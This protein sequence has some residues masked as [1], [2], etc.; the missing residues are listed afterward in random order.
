MGL[1]SSGGGSQTSTTQVTYSPE[2]QAARNNIFQAAGDT[3]NQSKAAAST[4]YA[5]P[6][7][8][9]PSA[10]TVAGWQLAAGAAPKIQDIADNAQRENSWTMHDALYA[11][12]NP[13]LQSAIT[14]A[15]KPLV[16]QFTN[17][18]GVLSGIR[19]NSV[20]N[21]TY[22]GSRQGIAEGLAMQGLQQKLGDISSTMAN[23]NYKTALMQRNDAIKMAPSMAMMQMLP[24][25]IQSDIGS[26]FEGYQQADENY[27]ANARDWQQNGMWQPL[28]NL[29]NIVYGGSNGT[30]TS[31]SSIPKQN[32]TGQVLGSLGSMALMGLMFSDRRLKR[33]VLRIGTHMLGI[34]WYVWDWLTG[35]RGEGVMAHEVEYVMPAAVV[36]HPSGFKMVNYAMLGA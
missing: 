15:Q 23:D 33:N 2:E 16:D 24:S 11:D 5:G 8:I 29:A 7:P 27:N 36:V 22:G 6:R 10:N 26:N 34:G 3:Y 31:T 14:A 25:Q 13:Y 12:S 20:A 21:G 17:A 35:G 19:N 28:A 1:Y 30:T 4:G 18:G 9:G 32:N